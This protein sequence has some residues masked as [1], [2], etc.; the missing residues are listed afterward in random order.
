MSELKKKRDELADKFTRDVDGVSQSVLSP[1]GCYEAGF[2]AAVA[3][4]R[5]EIEKL[6]EALEVTL[7]R[8]EDMNGGFFD[9]E[10]KRIRDALT[11][12]KQFMGEK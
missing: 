9:E 6:V 4:L 5:P 3:E 7:S 8:Y 1:K 11:N 2:D 10:S 12:F